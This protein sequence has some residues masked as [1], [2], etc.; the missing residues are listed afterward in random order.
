VYAGCGSCEGDAG[1]AH[2]K[3]AAVTTQ[4]D[5]KTVCQACTAEKK[6]CKTCPAAKKAKAC[7]SKGCKEKACK[8]ETAKHEVNTVT[9]EQLAQLIEA[10][11]NVVVLDARSGRYDDGRRIPGAKSLNAKS[12]PE[13]VAA[14][15]GDKDTKIVTYCS[16]VKCPASGYLAKHLTKLGYKNVIEYPEGIAGWAQADKQV[17]KAN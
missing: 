5:A 7:S 17:E 10:D 8:A 13:E 1:H 3:K 12:T 4:A 15:V 14:V 16:S 11:E 9:T 2:T 6:P